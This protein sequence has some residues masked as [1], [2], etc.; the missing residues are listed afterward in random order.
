MIDPSY[1]R[2]TSEQAGWVVAALVSSAEINYK[3][4]AERNLSISIVELAMKALAS[5]LNDHLAGSVAAIELLDHLIKEQSGQRLEKFLVDLRDDIRIDQEVLQ[6]LIGKLDLEESSMRKVSA[7]VVEKIGRV[8][9]SF[10]GDEAEDLGLLQALEGLALG[11]TGK[12][13]LWRALGTVERDLSPLQGVDLARL[14]QRAVDQFE[15]VEK[16]RLYLS[17][18]AF[19]DEE[20]T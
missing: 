5:Y 9:I 2:T 12:K 3:A 6:N 18:E 7:W 1:A 16:E 17:R 8:K 4:F 11:I 13:L 19:T 15:R 20:K 10:G 14:E